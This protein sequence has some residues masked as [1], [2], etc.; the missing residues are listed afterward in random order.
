MLT[1]S[2]AKPVASG[3]SACLSSS[4]RRFSLA[5]ASIESHPQYDI[6][7]RLGVQ[8]TI[9]EP[10]GRLFST[11]KSCPDRGLQIVSFNAEFYAIEEYTKL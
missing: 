7:R 4:R 2:S 11:V 3:V 5:F 9:M 6:L 10:A 8:G 1:H